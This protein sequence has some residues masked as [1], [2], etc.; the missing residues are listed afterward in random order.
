MA[1]A[2]ECLFRQS[3]NSSPLK[4]ILLFIFQVHKHFSTSFWSTKQVERHL[5][6]FSFDI[7]DVIKNTKIEAIFPSKLQLRIKTK[8]NN[9]AFTELYHPSHIRKGGYQYK[10]HTFYTEVHPTMKN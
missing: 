3:K 6:G 4:Y 7:T 10:Y 5:T 2:Q 9:T 8:T 1:K